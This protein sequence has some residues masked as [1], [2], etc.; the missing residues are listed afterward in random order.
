MPKL[1]AIGGGEIGR[2][3]K[4]I[5]TLAIDKEII[6]QSGKKHPKLLFIGTATKDWESYPETV[7][8]Y[9]GKKL[10][11]EVDVLLTVKEKPSLKTIK[12]KIL[13]TDIVY[14]GGGNTL[15]MIR[16]WKQLGIDKVLLEAYKKGVIMSGL[17]AGANCW[18]AYCTSDSRMI[19]DPTFKDYIRVK[20][21]GWYNIIISPHHITEKKRKPGL[22]KQIKR[23][24]G[25]GLALDDFTALEIIDDKFR[26]IVSKPQAK[27]YKVYKKNGKVLYEEIPKNKFYPLAALKM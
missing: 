20:G 9:F 7:K 22:I 21:L 12:D 8:K 26:I 14:V 13:G 3:G 1:I 23:H 11:C 25:I 18:F 27:A 17:S 10:G 19:T 2:P 24:G 16:K 6:K 4:P 5:E 15:F